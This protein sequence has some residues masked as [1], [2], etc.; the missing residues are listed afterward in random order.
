MHTAE[1]GVYRTFGL[2][3]FE[4]ADGALQRRGVLSDVSVDAA[5]VCRLARDC[6]LEQVRIEL[7]D[8]LEVEEVAGY[9]AESHA[10]L[11]GPIPCTEPV[12]RIADLPVRGVRDIPVRTTDEGRKGMLDGLLGI[13]SDIRVSA[14]DASSVPAG[15][16]YEV[17]CSATLPPMRFVRMTGRTDID[18]SEYLTPT[19]I[20]CGD[21]SG[22]LGEGE[23]EL[24]LVAPQIAVDVRN[25]LGIAL[26]GDIFLTPHG[27]AGE[28]LDSVGL[29]FDEVAEKSP[30]AL[31]GGQQ[32]RCAFAGVIAMRPDVLVLDEPVAGLDPAARREFLDLIARLNE[33]GLTVIMVSHSMDD[34]ASL[35]DRIVVLNEGR[36]ALE[37]A[38]RTVFARA[39]ELERIGLG[40]P[41]AERMARRLRAAGVPVD[42]G[43]FLTVDELAG[44]LCALKGVRS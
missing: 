37:G 16:E 17:R 40:L 18:L 3:L 14:A 33:Q 20:D 39:E 19:D 32:R 35:A 31:S 42:E 36:V 12:V 29:A 10:L 22:S 7:P 9:D 34:L 4:A 30:F 6:T 21:L 25:P 27:A 43:V 15:V 1:C 23:V 2:E 44:A 5:F 28:A 24:N 26:V 41:A 38:P 13:R 11:L 8:F